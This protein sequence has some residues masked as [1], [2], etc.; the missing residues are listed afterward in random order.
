MSPEAQR[1]SIAEACGWVSHGGSGA[2]V[3]LGPT[4]AGYVDGKL[5]TIPDYLSD[6]NAMSTAL[7]TLTPGEEGHYFR[8]LYTMLHRGHM[9]IRHQQ[10]MP[11]LKATAAQQAECFLRAKGK[12]VET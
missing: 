2:W 7:N 3:R 9:S 6:L 10:W 8:H 1:I 4:L 12:W 11:V 5:T